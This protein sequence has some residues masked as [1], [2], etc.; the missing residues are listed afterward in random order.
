MN[1]ALS[2]EKDKV[3][4]TDILSMPEDE[5][6]STLEMVSPTEIIINIRLM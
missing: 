5:L 4:I 3:T 1:Y 2:D 6:Y